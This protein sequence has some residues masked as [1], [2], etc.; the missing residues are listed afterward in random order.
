MPRFIN[1]EDGA[2]EDGW[3]CPSCTFHNIGQDD[4]C[5]MCWNKRKFAHTG[6]DPQTSP[7]ENPLFTSG[8]VK[9]YLQDH[10]KAAAANILKT[11]G[12]KKSLQSVWWI[13]SDGMWHKEDEQTVRHH[14]PLELRSNVVSTA[15]YYDS[16]L[17][18]EVGYIPGRVAAA[19]PAG[20][21]GSFG[22]IEEPVAAFEMTRVVEA[23]VFDPN[24]SAVEPGTELDAAQIGESEPRPET[25]ALA[26]ILLD[27]KELL[28]D[29]GFRTRGMTGME[30]VNT[31]AFVKEID[32][33]VF[34]GHE[35]D[36][37]G[38]AAA[39][40]HKLY[41]H[42]DTSDEESD[43]EADLLGKKMSMKGLLKQ[44]SLRSDKSERILVETERQSKFSVGQEVE[45][46]GFKL[47]TSFA[48]FNGR[49]ATI[50]Q[51]TGN[52]YVVDIK[53]ADG[54]GVEV[55]MTLNANK[56]SESR[57]FMQLLA[58]VL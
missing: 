21:E 49:K 43:H 55:T 37:V 8:Y 44:T 54:T 42:V 22:A 45:V 11:L 50:R 24:S 36:L 26:T 30:L 3:T 18:S 39:L 57:S 20:S 34:A 13:S 58:G 56:L 51:I 29:V 17:E 16:L 12:T 41:D 33:S 52:N 10:E 6:V 15:L 4:V 53:R 14:V 1:E 46:G 27:F 38:K 47:S 7:K 5:K 9:Q 35:A 28:K 19:P 31:V 40:W 48:S 32:S 25:P 23:E 2:Y